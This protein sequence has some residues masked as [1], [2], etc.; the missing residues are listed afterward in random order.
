MK[1][2]LGL[3]SLVSLLLP[4]AFVRAQETAPSDPG[5]TIRQSVQEVLLDVTVRD[6]RAA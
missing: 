4:S 3:F 6:S 5:L 2:L 1:R